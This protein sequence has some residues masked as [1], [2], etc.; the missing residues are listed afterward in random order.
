MDRTLNATAASQ[1][2]A[3][4][5]AGMNACSAQSIFNFSGKTAVVIGASNGGCRSV[6]R[7]RSGNHVLAASDQYW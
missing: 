4:T 6:K 5:L 2:N 1:R 3:G 7:K